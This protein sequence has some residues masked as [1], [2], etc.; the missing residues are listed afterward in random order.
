MLG[1]A[2]LRVCD[3]LDVLI[4]VVFV[5]R[6]MSS[7]TLMTARSRFGTLMAHV[8]HTYGTRMAHAKAQGWHTDGTRVLGDDMYM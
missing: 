2:L 3:Q 1:V 8:W 4:Y 5:T 7:Y 6:W